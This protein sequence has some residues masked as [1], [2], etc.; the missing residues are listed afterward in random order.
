LIRPLSH[1][2]FW[3]S[4]TLFQ[5]RMPGLQQASPMDEIRPQRQ[6]SS[7]SFAGLCICWQS[8]SKDWLLELDGLI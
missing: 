7:K 2:P 8:L 1:A 6:E 3:L 5:R 4:R